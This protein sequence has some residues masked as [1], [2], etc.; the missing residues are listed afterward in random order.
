MKTLVVIDMQERYI[1][2]NSKYD[3]RCKLI[4]NIN[5]KISQY[6]ENVIYVK[7]IT[8]GKSSDFIEELSVIND[9]VFLKSK[10][11]C[12]SNEKLKKYLLDK[13][14]NELEFVG[15]DGNYCIKSSA[16]DGKKLGFNILI[17][18]Q[19]IGARNNNK[20]KK[21]IEILKEKNIII[22]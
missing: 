4:D 18:V 12:F 10:A 14:I 17:D 8:L 20:L 15:I 21:T 9:V 16:L 22:K 3:D 1:G 2:K 5:A 6:N 7:N 11:S 13:N 19:S